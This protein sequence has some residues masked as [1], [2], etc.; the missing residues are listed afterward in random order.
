MY[1]DP[2]IYADGQNTNQNQTPLCTKKRCIITVVAV[3]VVVVLFVVIVVAVSRAVC[4]PK[5]EDC[6]GG[7][8]LTQYRNF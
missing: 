8:I 5:K 6:T 3:L 7:G 2:T 4:D 1:G